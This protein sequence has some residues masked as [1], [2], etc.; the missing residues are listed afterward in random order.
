MER[1][2]TGSRIFSHTLVLTELSE[3]LLLVGRVEEAA[4]LTARLL[5]LSRTHIGRGYEAHACRLLGDVAMHR[6]P[7]D[8]EQ[9]TTHYRQA[10]SL[11]E[12][13]GMRPLQAHCHH[14]LG[15]LYANTERPELARTELA[16]AI[17]L[18]RSID[19]TFWLPQVESALARM[20]GSGVPTK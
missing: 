4:T 1:L 19:M 15:I 5:E 8:V 13:L 7:P 6:D 3:A 12:D 9:A 18:Y 10:I 17:A 14:G 2:A 16:A 20:D 11:A